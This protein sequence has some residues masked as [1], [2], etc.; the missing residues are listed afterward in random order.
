VGSQKYKGQ[1]GKA[2][3]MLFGLPKGRVMESPAQR[4]H[5]I[6]VLSKSDNIFI[7]ALVREASMDIF[8]RSS[9]ANLAE[10]CAIPYE[11]IM[12]EY[13]SLQRQQGMVGMAMHL[14]EI[15]EQTALAARVRDETCPRCKG[16]NPKRVRLKNLKYGPCPRCEGVG[17]LHIDADPERLKLVF[18]TFG[19]TATGAQATV[20]VNTQVNV[21]AGQSME[22]LSRDVASIVDSTA[23]VSS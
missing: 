9:F 1:S 2:A 3:M 16:R 18:N 5:M 11:T 21:D 14:P 4:A 20:N 8:K 6:E 17:T 12:K 10:H 23:K 15:M 19:L 13:V 7:K 22:D